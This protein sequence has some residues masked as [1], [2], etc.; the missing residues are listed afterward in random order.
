MIDSYFTRKACNTYILFNSQK[1]GI[2]VDPGFNEGNYL[3]DHINKLGIE[4]KAIL[5]THGHYD[6]ISALET[7]I[8]KFPNAICYASEDEIEL[9]QNPKLNIS[10]FREDGSNQILT[11]LPKNIIALTDNEQ[12]SCCGFTIVMIKTPFHTGGSCCYYVE[13]EKALFTGD[14]LFYS[15]IGRTDLPTGSPKTV[16]SSLFKLVNLPNETTIY[17][18]HGVLSKLE[19]EKKFNSY[20][21]N[22]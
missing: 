14:T 13:S 1:E 9:I 10:Q 15:T 21:R 18:G 5:I 3:I 8:N 11:F 16:E 17:P 4:I 20:L 2:L 22:I 19:R 6:H 7:L 12:F